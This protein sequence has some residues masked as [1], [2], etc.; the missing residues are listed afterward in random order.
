M[1]ISSSKTLV[2]PKEVIFMTWSATEY[3]TN[4]SSFLS[5][6]SVKKSSLPYVIL[7]ISHSYGFW[8]VL[9]NIFSYISSWTVEL[10]Y[11]KI[12]TLVQTEPI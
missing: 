12:N 5:C 8:M 4:F 2:L 7:Q 1:G 10:N 3:V 6:S 9:V 11:A